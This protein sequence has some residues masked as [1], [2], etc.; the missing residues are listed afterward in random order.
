[1]AIRIPRT[2]RT[3]QV[4]LPQTNNLR[5]VQA[6]RTDLAG[7]IGSAINNLGQR[8]LDIENEKAKIRV[9]NDI[10]NA[11]SE[12][13]REISKKNNELFQSGYDFSPKTIK[14]KIQE[15]KDLLMIF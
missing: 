4:R 9:Q 13:S 7:D 12:L 11:E 3:R 2:T 15:G 5:L 8:I 10:I 1:M 6:T 14:D